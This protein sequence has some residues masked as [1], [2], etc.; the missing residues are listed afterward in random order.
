VLACTCFPMV[1]AELEALFPGVIYLD[2]GAYC[3]GLLKE[4]AIAQHRQ[5]NI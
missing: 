4:S 1:K 5:L 2:P 3:S